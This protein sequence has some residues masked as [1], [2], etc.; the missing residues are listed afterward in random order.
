MANVS[1]G[2]LYAAWIASPVNNPDED[3]LVL[4]LES[5]RAFQRG[6]EPPQDHDILS[7]IGEDPANDGAYSQEQLDYAHGLWLSMPTYVAAALK[8]RE[9]AS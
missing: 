1:V 8:H 2:K 9:N 7:I 4:I 3:M 5:L 6:M